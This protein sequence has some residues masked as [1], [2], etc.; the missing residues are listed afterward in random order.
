[1][2][3]ILYKEA[4]LDLI[5]VAGKSVY[6]QNAEIEQYRGI[7]GKIKMNWNSFRGWYV[8]AFRYMREGITLKGSIAQPVRQYMLERIYKEYGEQ[9]LCIALK[10]Y[11]GTVEYYEAQGV[12]KVGD[13]VIIQ[14]FQSLLNKTKVL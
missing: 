10:S 14:R 5:Y 6:E 3:K 7:C 2:A 11:I 13:R 4:V 9:G 1:M 12:R 8:P